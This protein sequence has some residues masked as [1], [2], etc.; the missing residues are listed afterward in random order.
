[1]NIAIITGASSGLGHE[2]AF[3]MDNIFHNIDEFWLIA[4]RKDKREELSKML[5]AETRMISMDI[6]KESSL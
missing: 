4:R 6:T 2:F 5:R 1:M 3:Q